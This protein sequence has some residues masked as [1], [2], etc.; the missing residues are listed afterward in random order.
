MIQYLTH[1]E[2]DKKKWDHTID[3][4][5]N[6]NVYA[7][8]WYLDRVHPY[9]EALI[10]GDYE[11]VMPLT[12]NK[13][14]GVHYL[15]QPFFTQQLGVY[16][17][18][19]LSKEHIIDFIDNIPEKF[20]FAEYNLNIYNHPDLGSPYQLIPQRNF[21][22]DLIDDYEKLY[23]HYNSNTKRN[24]KKSQ[25]HQFSLS[26]NIKPE[27]I[28]ELFVE[29]K[30]K[31]VTDWKQTEYLRL[32]GL[33]YMA[34]YKGKGI[35]YGVFTGKNELCAAAFFLYSNQHLTFLFSGSNK[36][37]KQSGAMTF[38]F[39][40]VIREYAENQMIMDFEGSNDP[41]LARFYKGFGAKEVQYKRLVY[42]KLPFPLKQML[43]LKKFMKKN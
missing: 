22:L 23:R 13:K 2:I 14:W 9:W 41:G 33:M 5:F 24:L 6:G 11:R 31:E 37:A 12:G 20:R 21:L 19:I 40:S 32:Q 28:V 10:E 17:I 38:L 7:Y 30:G 35:T 1:A 29:N 15:F 4:A 18:K 3:Q 34:Q 42:N 39:D 16:S 26:K 25:K 43:G 36:F 27:R 8:S